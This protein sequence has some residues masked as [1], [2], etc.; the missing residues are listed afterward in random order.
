MKKMNRLERNT[1]LV[2]AMFCVLFTSLIVYLTYF[3]VYERDRL[4]QSTYNRRLWEQE[5]KVMRGTIYDV[6]GRPLAESGIEN[7]VKRR[8]YPGKDATGPLIGYTDKKL[9]RAGLENVLNSELLGLSQKDPMALLRQKI[10]G[11]SDRGND[12]YLTIDLELQ[13]T[14]YEL[15]RGRRGALAAIDPN[16]GAVLALVSSPGFD[17]SQLSKNWDSLVNNPDKPLIN[18]A[19]QGLYPPGSTF[20]IITLAAALTNNP[21]IEKKVYH[22]PGYVKVKGSIIRD[23]E[24]FEPGDYDIVKAFRRSSNSVF[25]QIGQDVGGGKILEMAESF[26]FNSS[27]QTDVPTAVSRF[28]EPSLLGAEV[29]FAEASIGQGKILAT[30]LQM[31]RVAAIVANGGESIKPYVVHKVVSPL[32]EVKV[33]RPAKESGRIL[34]NVVAEKIK[35]L[36]ADVVN[37]GTGK[38]AQIKGITVAGKTGSAENPHG[39][40][41]AWFVGFAPAE[42]PKIAVAVVVENAGSGGANA[43]PIAREVMSKYI[44]RR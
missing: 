17:P 16:T 9:G 20:K 33:F 7:G 35:W 43:G 34:D 42:A 14:A 10:L 31:A 6:M 26:G 41:H 24:G 22:T 40:A 21:E 4:V 29:E 5:E 12:V 11:V 30:P 8:E 2:F 27:M 1:K 13:K 3:T 39:K 25:I 36:M 15:F 18:R 28:P 32:G 19:T 37:N 38:P 23:Y 44:N